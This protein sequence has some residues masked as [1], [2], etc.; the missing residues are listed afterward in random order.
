MIY[1]LEQNIVT[2]FASKYSKGAVRM[3]LFRLWKITRS[4]L[5]FLDLHLP[6]NIKINQC[7]TPLATSLAIEKKLHFLQT[8]RYLSSVV[9]TN[10][11]H[12]SVTGATAPVKIL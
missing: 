4:I 6:Y 1:V 11:T 12:V 2:C 8:S 10:L 7:R 3:R 5:L 9:P